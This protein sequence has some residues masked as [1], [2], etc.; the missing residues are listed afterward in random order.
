MVGVPVSTAPLSLAPLSRPTRSDASDPLLPCP[1][2]GLIAGLI[3]NAIE[4]NTKSKDTHPAVCNS[5]LRT[6]YQSQ[7]SHAEYVEDIEDEVR[8]CEAAARGTWS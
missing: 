4:V 2:P 7:V 3:I 6:S 1:L 8:V 5:T